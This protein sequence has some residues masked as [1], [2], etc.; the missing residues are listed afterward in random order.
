MGEGFIVRRGGGGQQTAKPIYNSLTSVDFTSLTLNVTNDSNSIATLYY[1]VVNNEPAPDQANTFDTEFA[2]KETK[3]ITITGLTAGT[4][5]TVYLK[6]I[7]VGEFPSETVIVPNLTTGVAMNATGGT[8]NTYTSGGKNYR[9]HTFTGNGTFQ[10]TQ[11]SNMGSTFNQVDYL[12]VAG[13]GGGGSTIGGGG[14]A[15]GYRTTVGL[16]GGNAAAEPKVS[17]TTT[18]YSIV[19]GAGGGGAGGSSSN[20]GV[21]AALG[22][23]S[24]ALNITSIGGGNGASYERVARTGGSGGGGASAGNSGGVS[25]QAGTA[26]QGF[27]GGNG[28]SN[29][30][31]GSVGAGGGGA[32]GAGPNGST[33]NGST[34]AGAGIARTNIIRNGSTA[35][36]YA[37]GGN[38]GGHSVGALGGKGGP[39]LTVPWQN[40]G[41]PNGSNGTVNTGSGGGGGSYNGNQSPTDRPGGAGGSGI[42]VIRYEIAP[43]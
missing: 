27:G 12:I 29:V 15:G 33:N 32:A 22:L 34:G 8:L 11:L 14:G 1:S 37:G 18:S 4:T 38:G 43:A 16:T 19:V 31:S 26:G 6:A 17:V 5:Y 41:N 23:N 3:D 7:A 9:S 28:V 2:G 36:A 13:G 30:G 21:Q 25:G 20:R 42:V 39:Q 35:V 40:T 10:V 24:S